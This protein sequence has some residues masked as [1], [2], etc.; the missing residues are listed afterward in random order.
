MWNS[1][2]FEGRI[3]TFEAWLKQISLGLSP[4]YIPITDIAFANVCL[5]RALPNRYSGWD[6]VNYD[7]ARYLKAHPR[8]FA[9]HFFRYK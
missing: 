4:F 1:M 5:G 3:S 8:L 9:V 6:L 7:M 2:A